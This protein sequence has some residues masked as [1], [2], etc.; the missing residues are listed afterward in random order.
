MTSTT[1]LDERERERERE[2]ITTSEPSVANICFFLFVLTSAEDLTIT[3]RVQFI[4]LLD[5]PGMIRLKN[6][7]NVPLGNYAKVADVARHGKIFSGKLLIEKNLFVLN[8]I[9]KRHIAVVRLLRLL[10]DLHLLHLLQLLLLVLLLLL[11]IQLN[12]T[13]NLTGRYF[14]YI[15]L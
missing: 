6:A 4:V 13:L 9:H 12:P 5:A 3:A 15:L 11:D 1:F 10:L 8:L 14:F 7:E 2:A